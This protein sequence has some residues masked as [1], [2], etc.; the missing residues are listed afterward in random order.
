MEMGPELTPWFPGGLIADLEDL[1]GRKIDIE[2][3]DALHWYIRDGFIKE[4]VPL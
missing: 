2:T 1:P 3:E 4:A